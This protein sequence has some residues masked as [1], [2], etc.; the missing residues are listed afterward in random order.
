MRHITKIVR[1]FMKLIILSALLLAS[2]FA[3]GQEQSPIPQGS[4]IPGLSAV[5]LGLNGPSFVEFGGDY[6]S[7]SGGFQRWEDAY[8]RGGISSGRN[9][10]NGELSRQSRYGDTGWYYSL[11]WTRS[12]SE[13]WYSELDFG[14]STVGGFFLPKVRTDALIN[15]KLL[16][17]R[18]LVVTLGGGYDLSKTV[19]SAYRG[20]IGATYYFER[21]WIIQGGVTWTHANPGSI[22]A[23]T[24]FVA[25]TQGHA[26]EHFLTL[27]AEVGR[28]GYELIGPQ[29]SLFDFPIQ[30]YSAT[31][32]QWL[33]PNWGFN[34]ILEHEETPFYHRNGGT[35][36]IFLEF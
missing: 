1:Q 24:Q 17:R 3:V 36:A 20:Q 28:E 18:Q 35:L 12:W 25:V 13:N 23:R 9:N 34:A 27:R 4:S 16:S 5:P 33:G 19:N 15:R 21:P 22:L 29:T 31:W 10:F 7:L 11:G 30:N 6:N 14:S 2:A 32:R 8:L 26:K